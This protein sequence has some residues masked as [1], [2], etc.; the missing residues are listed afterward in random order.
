MRQI[1]AVHR[2][3]T[4]VGL[5]AL[6]LVLMV[7]NTGCLKIGGDEPLLRVGSEP[8]P[9]DTSRVPRVRSVEQG[10]QIVDDAY[11]RIQY[12]ERELA[13]TKGDLRKVKRERDRCEDRL[14]RLTDD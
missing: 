9:V 11:A 10:Q 2:S 4:L 12:L 3:V 5:F 6:A 13:D 7:P 14:E 8:P 1:P